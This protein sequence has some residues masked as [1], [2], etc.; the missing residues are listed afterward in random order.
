MKQD[1]SAR[2]RLSAFPTTTTVSEVASV[3]DSLTAS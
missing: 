1:V 2:A 3:I